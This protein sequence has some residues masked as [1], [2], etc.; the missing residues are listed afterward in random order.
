VPTVS[1]IIPSYRSW[2]LIEQTLTALQRQTYRD[3]VEIIVVDS[4]DDGSHEQIAAAFPDVRLIHL[5]EQTNPGGARNRGIEAATAPLIAFVDADA[6]P[7]DR[8]LEKIVAAH[9]AHP[10]FAGIG[11]SISNANA[12]M[13]VARV[14]HLL[15]FSGYTPSWP[16]RAARVIPTCNL[17]FKRGALEGVR[18]LESTWGNEDVEL[19][20]RLRSEGALIWFDP[21]IQVAH[22]SK[23]NRADLLAQ[24]RKLGE[25][26]GRVRRAYDLP[27]SWLAR[28]PGAW[29]LCP[30]LKAGILWRRALTHETG[31]VTLLLTQG[32]LI[33]EAL[34]AWTAG[35]RQGLLAPPLERRPS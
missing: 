25:S 27:G 18:F 16:A 3:A 33:A 32:P 17:S 6:V 19:V 26:T 1:V 35:F 24:Q 5:T 13:V 30:W 34:L 8:W 23:S 10:D 29:V 20:E 12:S 14:A 11:G 4:S 28:I 15:E 7:E 31:G 22:F 2:P 21:T 9:E